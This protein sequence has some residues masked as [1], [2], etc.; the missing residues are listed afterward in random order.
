MENAFSI[1]P[2]KHLDY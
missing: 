1:L 2:A